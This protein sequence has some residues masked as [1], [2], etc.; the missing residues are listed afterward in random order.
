MPQKRKFKL[1]GFLD[2]LAAT[3]MSTGSVARRLNCCHSTCLRYLRENLKELNISLNNELVT[4]SISGELPE[5]EY[6]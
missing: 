2:I 4:P 3:S 5:K 1:E 6:F